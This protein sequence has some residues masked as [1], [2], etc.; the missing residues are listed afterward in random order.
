MIIEFAG[1][2]NFLL[3]NDVGLILSIISQ[4]A[5]S[6]KPYGRLPFLPP[7]VFYLTPCSM[8]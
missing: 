2:S 5:P 4:K 1:I 8:W 6:K 7:L 3:Y